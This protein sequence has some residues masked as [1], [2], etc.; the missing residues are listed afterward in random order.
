[1][2]ASSRIPNLTRCAFQLIADTIKHADICSADRSTSDGGFLLCRCT[3]T[4]PN[5]KPE[6]F[7]D[8]CTPDGKVVRHA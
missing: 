6:R 3:H 8:A 4:N 1:M 5:F 7:R 2:K